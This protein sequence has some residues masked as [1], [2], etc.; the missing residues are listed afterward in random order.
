VG[1]SDALQDLRGKY[2]VSSRQLRRLAENALWRTFVFREYRSVLLKETGIRDLQPYRY[3]HWHLCKYFR[4]TLNDQPIFIKTSKIKNIIDSEV[5]NN[6]ILSA[7]GAPVLKVLQTHSWGSL[8][9]VIMEWFD[10]IT[11]RDFVCSMD[12]SRFAALDRRIARFVQI[13]DA[14]YEG[15]IVHRDF[16]PDNLLVANDKRVERDIVLIDLGFAGSPESLAASDIST[17]PWILKRLGNGY[18]EQR[19]IWDDAFAAET[20]IRW[21]EKKTKRS[22]AEVRRELARREGRLVHKCP[23]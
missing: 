19:L 17:D 1:K 8:C 5:S 2:A 12:T 21:V 7:T 14:L 23:C 11:L 3:A 22:L 4:G 18:Y 13:I 10:G 20:I 6:A 16:T 9:S 15:N